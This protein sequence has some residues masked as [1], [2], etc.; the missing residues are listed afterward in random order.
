MPIA[1]TSI[2]IALHFSSSPMI[3]G[4]SIATLGSPDPVM[5]PEEN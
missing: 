3:V 4:T 2:E 1:S 5:L